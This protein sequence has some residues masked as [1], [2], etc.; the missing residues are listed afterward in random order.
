MTDLTSS[1]GLPRLSAEESNAIM[2]TALQDRSLHFDSI[3]LLAH[4][5]SLGGT[6]VYDKK[7]FE[8][9]G[10][11]SERK[12]SEIVQELF[13]NRYLDFGN[14]TLTDGSFLMDGDN[15]ACIWHVRRVDQ[16]VTSEGA[17][18]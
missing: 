16:Q 4:L 10:T 11:G 7:N 6:I 2:A 17:E 9:I 3:G 13:K 18:A 12:F 5:V 1:S 14:V 15:A 8:N